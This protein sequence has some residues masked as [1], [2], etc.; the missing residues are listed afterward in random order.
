MKKY[1]HKLLAFLSVL[2]I[3]SSAAGFAFS[4]SFSAS[5]ADVSYSP[6]SVLSY[7]NAAAFES[8]TV[9][10]K[11][12]T[13]MVFENESRVSYR[14]DLAYRWFSAK[15]EERFFN[16]ELF[17]AD[18]NFKEFTVTFESA[19]NSKIKDDKTTNTLTFLCEGD[20]LFVKC[21]DGEKTAL[22]G[23]SVKIAFGKEES[24]LSGIYQV[25][26]N[27]ES[28]GN[29]ENIGGYF[30]EFSSSTITPLT[31]TAKVDGEEKTKVGLVSL[32]GQS[33]A[34]NEEEKIVDD[35]VP[36]LVV[37]QTLASVKLGRTFSMAYEVIDV[38]DATVSKTLE[39]YQYSPN[40]EE[41]SY[42]TLSTSKP[43]FELSGVEENF[44]SIRM[45]LSD[46]N[47]EH[48]T[49]YDITWYA[50]ADRV[51]TIGE[52][53]YLPLVK[54]ELP[55]T[56][57]CMVETTDKKGN[58]IYQLDTENEAYLAYQKA[59]EKAAK[60]LAAGS[61]N[62]FYL[63]SL[64]DLVEDEETAYNSLTFNIYYKTQNSSSSSS[65]TNLSSSSLSIATNNVGYYTFRVVPVDDS[66]NVMTVYKD[67][68]K[69]TVT[70]SNVWDFDCIPEFGFTAY[71][72]GATI[73]D[74]EKKTSGYVDQSYTL[75]SFKVNAISGYDSTYTL[76][77]FEGANAES[78]L[79]YSKLIEMANSEKT[80]ENPY[81]DFA[82]YLNATEGLY[83]RKIGVYDSS[84]EEDTDEWEASDNAYAW[85]GSG[86][87]FVPQE[88]G[89]YVLMLEVVDSE[90]WGDKVVAYQVIEVA[91]E[92]DVVKGET[93]WL[94]DNYISVIFF[95]LAGV[96]LIAVI[97]LIVVKPKEENIEDIDLDRLDKKNRKK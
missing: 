89:Y 62:Y 11:A 30:A 29:F 46:D 71:N 60:N 51:K 77:Y 72:M 69:V 91:S 84:I 25:F 81:G 86:A 15:G 21:N 57:T 37:N 39:Y 3:G 10:G 64:Q 97:V 88:A 74:A 20:T 87:S 94:R 52:T 38:L 43:F 90:L 42:Q 53:D 41:V 36:V 48:D 28:V 32:N 76:Y 19:S 66:G 14:Q 22:A 78:S 92:K 31:F 40:D 79:T 24:A 82:K 35:A 34:L 9:E 63:P 50:E 27:G 73:D 8:E 12:T 55:P 26:V 58:K 75:P 16:M 5:A 49:V 45:K 1:K 61:G 70:S 83:F 17:F 6:T 67:G 59:V 2:A 33:F 68:R 7:A 95:S 96:L 44:V 54:D 56:Y 18:R 85:Y 23:S 4:D 80:A 13:A 47:S 65:S 93:Y